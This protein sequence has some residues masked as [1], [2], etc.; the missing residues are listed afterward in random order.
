[1]ERA[2]GKLS[3]GSVLRA[4]SDSSNPDAKPLNDSFPI[5]F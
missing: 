1:M 3:L 2:L 4:M 5:L